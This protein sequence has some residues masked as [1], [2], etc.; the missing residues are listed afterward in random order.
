MQDRFVLFDFDGVIADS[1]ALAFDV[2]RQF[3]P[4]LDEVS[5]KKLFEGNIYE[6]LKSMRGWEDP[7][8]SDT[9]FAVFAPRMKDEVTL[10]SGMREVIEALAKEFTLLIV[11]STVSISITEFLQQHGLTKYFAESMGK[12]VHPS[13]VEKM[14]MIFEKYDTSAEHCVFITDTLGDM[15][16]AKEHGMGAIGVSWGFHSHQTLGKGIP[17]R[18]VD[19]PAEL[20]D[21]VADYFTA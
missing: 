1:F 11:S 17:F 5:Y 7:D 3:N 6:S 9:Y 16:E 21:A 15:R 19:T 14:R 2:S 13:K 10:A 4:E 18:I 20:P 8:R 12:D